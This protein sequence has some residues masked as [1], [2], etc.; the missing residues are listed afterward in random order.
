MKVAMLGH[1]VIPSH[2][3]GIET[4]LSSLCPRLAK[5]EIEIV[6]YNRSGDRVEPCYENEISGG[7]WKGVRL[8]SAPTLPLRGFS[9]MVASYTAAV[10]A[11]FSS[12]DVV[13]FHAE[14]PC[15]AMWIPK[16][17]GK[18]CV[19]TVHFNAVVL[20]QNILPVSAF[21]VNIKMC[22]KAMN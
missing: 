9:A 6:C 8:R 4:V 3:G 12:C 5:R 17:F 7:M 19:A 14:G 11:A 18:K 21:F 2:R 16:L 15:G 1:K 10:R 22:M 13:H 20:H